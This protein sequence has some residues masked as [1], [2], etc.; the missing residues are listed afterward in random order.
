MIIGANLIGIMGSY[1]TA[2]PCAQIDFIIGQNRT[3]HS[4]PACEAFYN[5]TNTLQQ[6][7]IHADMQG[8]AAEK[9]AALGLTFG[10]AGWL[11]LWIHAVAVE[12][13]VSCC[14]MV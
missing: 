13:Y 2:R 7:V 1:F 11:A 14:M 5:G 6:V 3:M 9:A 4:Y 8:T 12:V 10:A